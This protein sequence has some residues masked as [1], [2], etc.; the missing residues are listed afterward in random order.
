MIKKQI[1]YRLKSY[2]EIEQQHI[3]DPPEGKSKWG[4]R[5]NTPLVN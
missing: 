2:I 3:F 5:G 1:S 4:K